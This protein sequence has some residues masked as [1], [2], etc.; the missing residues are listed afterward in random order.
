MSSSKSGQWMPS[1]RPMRRRLERSVCVPWAKRGNQASGTVMV[2]P[3]AR[4]TMRASSFAAHVKA[5][6]VAEEVA[7][8]LEGGDVIADGFDGGGDGDGEDEADGAPEGAP[9]HKGYRDG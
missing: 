8:A 3:S 5:P 7:V 6:S 4:S 2:L 9:E 1:P